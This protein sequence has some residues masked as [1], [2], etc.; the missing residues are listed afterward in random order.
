MFDRVILS[1]IGIFYLLLYGFALVGYVA[2]PS[3][4][5]LWT[6]VLPWTMFIKNVSNAGSLVPFV[7]LNGLVIYVLAASFDKKYKESQ[8]KSLI[9]G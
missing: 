8:E 1:K 6:L 9:L 3:N 7:I 5:I 2:S 4:N